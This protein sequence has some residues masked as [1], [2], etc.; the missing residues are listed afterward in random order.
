MKMLGARGDRCRQLRLGSLPAALW[1]RTYRKICDRRDWNS[2]TF[3]T[4]WFGDTSGSCTA[5]L[6]CVLL[7]WGFLLWR[8]I[9]SRRFTTETRSHGEQKDEAQMTDTAGKIRQTW[10][11]S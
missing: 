2:R 3:G 9:E 4:A 7:A 10:S 11:G 1:R 8:K 6:D 5:D